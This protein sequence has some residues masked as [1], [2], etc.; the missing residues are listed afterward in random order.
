MCNEFILGKAGNDWQGVVSGRKDCFESQIASLTVPGL[1]KDL[2]PDFSNTT[3]TENISIQVTVMDA[4]KK[5][6]SYKC[7]TRCGFP[8]ITLE[9]TEQD[10]LNLR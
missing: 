8:S 1:S 5:F 2:T 7:M 9:G 3:T 6:F 10:W 4:C